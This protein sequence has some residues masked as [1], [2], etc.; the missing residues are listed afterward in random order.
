MSQ[1]KDKCFVSLVSNVNFSSTENVL[2]INDIKLKFGRKEM[3][4][5]ACQNSRFGGWYYKNLKSV[6][7]GSGKTLQNVVGFFFGQP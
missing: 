1:S 3:A 2:L 4:A 6:S 5:R 7:E